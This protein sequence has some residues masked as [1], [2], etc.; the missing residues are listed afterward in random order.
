M[1]HEFLK[2]PGPENRFVNCAAVAA[3][4]SLAEGQACELVVPAMDD[5]N[6]GTTIWNPVGVIAQRCRLAP[7]WT[8]SPRA[9]LVFDDGGDKTTVEITTCEGYAYCD[10]HALY[11]VFPAWE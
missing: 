11:E 9:R 1:P 8:G 10:P 2:I 4:S 5:D 7:F 3:V 6:D